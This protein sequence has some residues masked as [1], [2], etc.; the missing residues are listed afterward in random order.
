[1]IQTVVSLGHLEQC[2]RRDADADGD[3][4]GGRLDPW[5]TARRAHVGQDFLNCARL[6]QFPQVRAERAEVP[7]PT[8]RPLRV[9]PPPSRLR[10]NTVD[11]RRTAKSWLDGPKAICYIL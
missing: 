9:S 5:H 4:Q 10:A 7:E 1:M 2:S 11:D 6:T 8:R 3:A